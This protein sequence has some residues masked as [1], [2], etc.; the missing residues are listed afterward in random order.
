MEDQ[1]A[2]DAIRGVLSLATAQSLV[3]EIGRLKDQVV[4]LEAHVSELE[5]LAHIDPLVRLPNRRGLF[6]DLENFIA[7]LNR[8]GG[9]AALIFVDID[10]LKRINDRFGHSTGDAALIRIAQI[11]VEN[12]RDS[13]PVGRLSGDEF[14]IL[15]S[16]VDELAAWNM[17]LRIVEAT[18]ASSSPINSY[19]VALSIAVGVSV[20][21]AGDQP[22]DVISR[23]DKAMYR[24][25]AA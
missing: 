4:Q 3:D 16:D 8:Y 1:P 20:I 24:I 17:A 7:R 19:R 9:T 15:L 18:V 22:E 5:E 23:A 21:N 10:G 11:L 12:V 25:K 2:N 14:V 13:D 6:R